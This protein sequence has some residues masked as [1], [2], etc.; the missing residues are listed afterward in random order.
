MLAVLR[1]RAGK[2]M[3]SGFFDRLWGRVEGSEVFRICGWQM[4]GSAARV[5]RLECFLP[6]ALGRCSRQPKSSLSTSVLK[7]AS[8]KPNPEIFEI[9]ATLHPETQCNV[10]PE[11][12]SASLR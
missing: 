5:S 9:F 1:F 8:L 11:T 12:A 4:L 2:P 6:S 10:S 3:C 7:A